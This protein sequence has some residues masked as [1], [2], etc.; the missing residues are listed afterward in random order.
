MKGHKDDEGIG[1]SGT[2]GKGEGVG[3]L[4]LERRRLR[5]LIKAHKHPIGGVMPDPPSVVSCEQVRGYGNKLK[6]KEFHLI[7][8][9]LSVNI[10]NE[11]LGG[12]GAGVASSEELLCLYPW[13]YS[14]PYGTQHSH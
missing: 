1:T 2:P 5:Y 10:F 3:L 7:I 12:S 6:H 9:S 8:C 13:R 11:E 14:K 4:N